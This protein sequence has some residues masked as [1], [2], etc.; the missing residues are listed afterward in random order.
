MENKTEMGL[1]LIIFGMALSVFGSLGGVATGSSGGSG[2]SP[3]A[4]IPLILGFFGFILI[5]VGF[6]LMFIGRKEFGEKHAQFA[7]YSLIAIIIG[8]IIVVIGSMIST[9]A[10][11]AGGLESADE[12]VTLDY[13][14]MARSMKT[15]LIFTQI[16]GISIT[17]GW[18]L[19][20][21]FLE[22]DIGKRILFLAFAASIIIAI[23]ALIYA[24]PI[25]DDLADKLENTPEEEH[26]EEFYEG[27]TE[28]NVIDGLAIIGSVLLLIGY[29]IPYNRI[30]KGELKPV[31]KPTQPYGMPPYPPQ[32]QYQPY[33]PY[34]PPYQPPQQPPS[35]TEGMAQPEATVQPKAVSPEQ[36]G[37]KNCMFCGTQIP[38]NSTTCP[39]CK[40]ELK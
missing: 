14:A 15:A 23:I 16:G 10:A 19:L 27:L 7:I 20:V 18:V 38:E 11:I 12:G 28:L 36:V 6:I 35:K 2:L 21:Y 39:V 37:I 30:K 40:K 5:L 26:E 8:V 17:I 25:F 1:L 9:F 32:Q 3:G 4:L 31:T 24:P 22:N 29:L 33:S 34:Q 13:V